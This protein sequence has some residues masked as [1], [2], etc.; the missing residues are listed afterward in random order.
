MGSEVI[1]LSG[2]IILL[3]F[4]YFNPCNQSNFEVGNSFESHY[5]SPNWFIFNQLQRDIS[6]NS[7]PDYYL[8]NQ[9]LADNGVEPVLYDDRKFSDQTGR[10]RDL[11]DRLYY[12]TSL[13]NQYA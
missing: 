4:I 7:L 1:V 13:A 5:S 2:I 3:L 10:E 12:E 11:E 9:I 6:G 8:E